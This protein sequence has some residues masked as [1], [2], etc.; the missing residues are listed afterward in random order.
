MVIISFSF[1][2]CKDSEPD[3]KPTPTP[4]AVLSVNF[5]GTT[6]DADETT[7]EGQNYTDYGVLFFSAFKFASMDSLPFVVVQMPNETG[8]F[9]I[10]DNSYYLVQYCKEFLFEYN[11]KTYCDWISDTTGSYTITKINLANLSTSFVFEGA[12]WNAR[13]AI[14]NGAE[15]QKVN[16]KLTATDIS[17]LTV[18]EAMKSPVRKLKR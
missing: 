15:I 5:D 3:P 8:T 14:I 13:D 7:I 11:G 10:K 18:T 2:A 9:S 16:L 1:L 6:W 4:V 17:I 12:L